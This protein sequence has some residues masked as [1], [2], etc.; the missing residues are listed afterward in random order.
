MTALHVGISFKIRATLGENLHGSSTISYSREHLRHLHDHHG[1]RARVICVSSDSG[2][3]ADQYPLVVKSKLLT[4]KSIFEMR[5]LIPDFR[6]AEATR[7]RTLVPDRLTLG[8]LAR[9]KYN[10]PMQDCYQDIANDRD[11]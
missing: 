2:E 8:H 4:R 6:E 10:Q 5:A 1:H 3:L 9:L 7:K 11:T